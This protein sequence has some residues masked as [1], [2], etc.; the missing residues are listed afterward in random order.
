MTQAAAAVPAP[1]PSDRHGDP[2]H[3]QPVP[4]HPAT[5]VQRPAPAL[6]RTLAQPSTAGRLIGTA[7]PTL[8]KTLRSLGVVPIVGP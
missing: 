3:A 1:G 4:V 7:T 8:S 2:V 5:P 6:S